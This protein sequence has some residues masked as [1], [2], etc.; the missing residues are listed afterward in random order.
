MN[1]VKSTRRFEAFL[2]EHCVLLKD[3]LETKHRLMAENQFS[4]LRATFYR[5]AQVFPE[6][7]QEA[8][9]SPRVLGVGDLH[10]ENFGTWRDADGRLVW[11]INDFDEVAKVP[12][13]I[14]LV[15][16]AVSAALAAE[17]GHLDIPATKVC[18]SIL[19]GYRETIVGDGEPIVLAERHQWLAAL[20][21][22][23]LKD[24]NQFWTKIESLSPVRKKPPLGAISAIEKLMPERKLKYRLLRRVAG[25]GSLGKIRVVALANWRGS[26][27]AREAK[28]ITPSAWFWAQGDRTDELF[29]EKLITR[30][31]RCPDPWV[32]V[33][34]RW[35]CRRLAPDCGRV[36]LAE[37]AKSL[38]AAK[39]LH[40]MGHETANI[41][42]GS[43]KAIAAIRR[44]LAKRKVDWLHRAVIG[45]RESLH[46]D[47]LQWK[48]SYKKT[49]E[50]KKA[51]PG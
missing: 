4:F 9:Q 28:S 29:Y 30:A 35:V 22:E 40:A 46:S 50:S 11:G 7:C 39:L 17:S 23:G 26:S 38:Q 31:V 15:R 10:V 51:K 33:R 44:D 49:S 43:P 6:V 45:M 1:I 32:G 2:A 24:P 37:L 13:T 47:W 16:L 20:A 5:W 3:D 12:Y 19:A 41:H 48:E 8:A 42:L 25:L 27:I 14:D 34:G 36:E 21:S 18:E